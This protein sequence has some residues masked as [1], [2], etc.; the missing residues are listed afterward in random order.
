MKVIKNVGLILRNTVLTTLAGIL[1]WPLVIA[2]NVI[3]FPAQIVFLCVTRKRRL[4]ERDR[5]YSDGDTFYD[6]TERVTK[7]SDDELVSCIYGVMADVAQNTD[8]DMEPSVIYCMLQYVVI[9]YGR[10]LAVIWEWR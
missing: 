5:F 6:L 3:T 2:W 1:Y 7:E 4:K 9:M 8:K 10:L